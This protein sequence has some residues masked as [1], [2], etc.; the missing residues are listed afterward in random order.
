MDN[1]NIDLVSVTS[2]KYRGIERPLTT[3]EI[4]DNTS[5]KNKKDIDNLL[6]YYYEYIDI[7]F[8]QI[9][10]TEELYNKLFNI[11]K[12]FKQNSIPCEIILF[13]T[14]P[15]IEFNDTKL[16]FLGYDIA[17]QNGESLLA[18]PYTRLVSNYLNNNG[19]CYDL[20]NVENIKTILSFDLLDFQW[21]SYYVYNLKR[22]FFF[23]NT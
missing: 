11:F 19:L 4:L 20:S 17:N 9:L 1:I 13:S 12:I 23:S 18:S 3:N 8:N 2:L 21:Q 6:E 22:P 14:N 16:E 5:K 7:T 15:I 10:S